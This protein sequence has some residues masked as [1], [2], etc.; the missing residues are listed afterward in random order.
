MGEWQDNPSSSMADEQAEAKALVERRANLNRRL[1]LAFIAGAE[2]RSRETMGR[3][4][5][6]E[7]LERIIE[8]YPGDVKD[9]SRA[10]P[11]RRRVADSRDR[12]S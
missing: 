6:E 7:E 5:S 10:N 1:R 2:E 3:G 11:A 9:R 8:R 12:P 4:L